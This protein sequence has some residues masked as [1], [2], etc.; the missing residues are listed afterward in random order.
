MNR[1]AKGNARLTPSGF[2]DAFARNNLPASE[3]WPVLDLS[4]PGYRF[5]PRFNCAQALLHTAL[6]AG[7]GPR[8][9]LI[10]PQETLTYTA[11]ESR[12]NQVAHA[13]TGLPGFSSGQ[14]VLL[15]G[16]NNPQFVASWLG[17]VKAG[18]IAVA[19]MPLL[20]AQELT[21]ILDAAD[22]ALALC[23]ERWLGEL[24]SAGLAA[25]R[26][27]R[28]VAFDGSA[29]AGSELEQL[30]TDTPTTFNAVDTAADDVA[31]IA[32][33][34]G[35]T[36]KPKGTMHFHR[37]VLAICQGLPRHCLYARSSDRF[38][39][40]PPLAFTFGLGGLALFPLS[41]GA[42]GILLEDAGPSALAAGI[43]RFG[44]TVCFTAPTAYRAMLT[45]PAGLKLDSLRCSVSAGETLPAATFEA[46]QD[47]TGL[48]SVDS[49]GSTEL[50]HAFVASPPE[51]MRAGY[52]GEA[53]AG[54]TA[55]VVDDAMQSVAPGV[56]GLLAIRGPTGC[57]YLNDAR[58]RE[59]VHDGWNL[60]G[61]TYVV[62]ESGYFRFIARSDDMII[63][64]GYNI[65][66]PEVETA[67]LSHASVH[68][69]AVVGVADAQ[70]GQLVHAYVVTQTGE[71]GDSRL[72][73]ELQN[74]VKQTIAPYKY[75]RRISF[76][77]ALPR[78]ET[79]KVQRFKLRSIDGV[80]QVD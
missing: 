38:I 71:S 35:T 72:M 32:F 41:V 66:G 75:P 20:R 8:P 51:R 10:S 80:S 59:Y 67:L 25:Q 64:A 29:S 45:S 13:L 18:G 52:T 17:I 63:S 68:E 33:T 7:F 54:Y 14:R 49:L 11:L 30:A 2:E 12:S 42:A 76:I 43:E 37:D 58:Q 55:R 15:R 48:A 16:P 23:D 3:D 40:S 34:S 47:L 36:G 69:C 39:G 1:Q 61:D 57:R 70:R 5:A 27:L 73:T 74:H 19:T 28:I 79:G 65:A 53:L 46:W 62:D 31:L 22:V 21:S 9:A 50:L 4:H 77:D 56:A 24:E 26:P 44:A 6:A 78:T 60:T